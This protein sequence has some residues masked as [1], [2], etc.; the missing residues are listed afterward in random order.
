MMCGDSTNQLLSKLGMLHIAFQPFFLNLCIAALARRKNVQIRYMNDIILR[1]CFVAGVML[2]SRY[3]VMQMFWPDVPGLQPR[4]SESCPNYE[5]VFDG[6][7]G[8]LKKDTPNLPGHPCTFIPDTPTAHL[9][10]AYPGFAPSY[11]VPCVSL[12]F[13]LMFAPFLAHRPWVGVYPLTC[14]VGL[15]WLHSKRTSAKL[16]SYFAWVEVAS[17]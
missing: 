14:T 4:N 16:G 2:A 10:W 17:Y 8:Y 11:L 15:S 5:W 13:F 12:H 6:F 7:D 3:F 1:L 9:A